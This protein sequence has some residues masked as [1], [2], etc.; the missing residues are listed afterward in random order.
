MRL[1]LTQFGLKGYAVLVVGKGAYAEATGGGYVSAYRRCV[2]HV[3]LTSFA[4]SP[5]HTSAIRDDGIAKVIEN[6]ACLLSRS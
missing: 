6:E 3:E 5:L 2:E 1:V 4:Y